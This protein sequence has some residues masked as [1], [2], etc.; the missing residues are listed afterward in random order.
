MCKIGLIISERA[1]SQFKVGPLTLTYQVISSVPSFQ[2][3]AGIAL[4]SQVSC[5]LHPDRVLGPL[6]MSL[7]S[8]HS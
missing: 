8:Y 2:K 1:K 7:M 6:F 5:R 3:S 4:I